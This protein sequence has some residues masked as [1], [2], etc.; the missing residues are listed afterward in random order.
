MWAI[1]SY[2][3]LLSFATFNLS[4]VSA[5][6][7]IASYASDTQKCSCLKTLKPQ[8]SLRLRHSPMKSVFYPICA[9]DVELGAVNMARVAWP[10]YSKRLEQALITITGRP[11]AVAMIS[12][13]GVVVRTSG[14]RHTQ[15]EQ[16]WPNIACFGQSGGETSAFR[17]NLC[18]AHIASTIRPQQGSRARPI[19]CQTFLN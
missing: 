5:S 10:N 1:F 16:I 9:Y 2:G 6:D 18:V 19:I 13:R 7:K 12:S 11:K 4:S 3:A 17:R 15:I 8:K 14:Y